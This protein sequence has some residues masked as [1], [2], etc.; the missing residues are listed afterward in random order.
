MP[1]PDK[2]GNGNRTRQNLMD[3][4]LAGSFPASD[5]P[6]WSSPRPERKLKLKLN[7]EE[8]RGRP[9]KGHRNKFSRKDYLAG[10]KHRRAHATRTG[11]RA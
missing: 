8:S 6:S 7:E 3:E 9:D 10:H 1:H 4:T 2:N 11:G 5:P